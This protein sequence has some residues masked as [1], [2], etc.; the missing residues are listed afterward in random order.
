LTDSNCPKSDLVLDEEEEELLNECKTC[1]LFSLLTLW[2]GVG[3]HGRG[4]ELQ[5]KVHNRFWKKKREERR[6]V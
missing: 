2:S 3:G 1:A 6:E 5:P 4:R